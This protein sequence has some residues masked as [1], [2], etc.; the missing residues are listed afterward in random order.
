MRA[1]HGGH[2]SRQREHGDRDGDG[3][4]P[5]SFT[6]RQGHRLLNGYMEHDV[7]ED[8]GGFDVLGEWRDHMRARRGL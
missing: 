1:A 5:R 3:R 2:A 4:L 7:N 6:G 8:G